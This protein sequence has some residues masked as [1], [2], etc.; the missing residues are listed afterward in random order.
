MLEIF[1]YLKQEH[2]SL[3]LGADR[4]VKRYEGISLFTALGLDAHTLENIG[5]GCVQPQKRA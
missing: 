2:H 5:S 4:W 1:P 3:T